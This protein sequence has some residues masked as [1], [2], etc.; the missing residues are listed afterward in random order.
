MEIDS[1]AVLRTAAAMAKNSIPRA[2]LE[3]NCF[4]TY[5]IPFYLRRIKAALH[6]DDD[7]GFYFAQPV[8]LFFF[9]PMQI[10]FLRNIIYLKYNWSHY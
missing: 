8:I 5:L 2:A 7:D 3:S 6:D 1:G 4:S 10:R 9:S